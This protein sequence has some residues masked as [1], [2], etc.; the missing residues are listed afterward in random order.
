VSG[1]RAL[2]ATV[3]AVVGACAES[4]RSL[5]TPDTQDVDTADTLDPDTRDPDSNDTR[6]PDSNDTRDLDS[7]DTLDLDSNDTLD[8]DSNDTLDPDTSN[9][10]TLRGPCPRASRLGGFQVTAELDYAYVEGSVSDGVVPVTVLEV[11]PDSELGD[12]RLLAKRNPFCDPPCESG[13]TCD[14]D[15]ACIAYPAPLDL[16]VVTVQGLLAPVSMTALEPGMSYFETRLPNPPWAAGAALSL[17]SSGGASEPLALHALAIPTLVPL[18]PWEVAS[19]GADP[20]DLDV[21]W[22]PP[23][24]PSPSLEVV[25]TLLID[26]HGNAPRS[27]ECRFADTGH[28]QVPRALLT[29]LVASGVSGYPS[30]RLVRRSADSQVVQRPVAGCIDL[31]ATSPRSVPVSVS[32]HIPCRKD[33]DC[34]VDLTCDRPTETCVP[35]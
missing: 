33:A 7:N 19:D 10:P 30:G 25:L 31:L 32:G 35:R 34:P 3:L 15:G 2:L 5:T 21:R 23:P 28:G 1:S 11:V 22:E 29:A 26:Q 9:P 12:C 13:E 27:L 14:F 18:G 24:T 17:S 16:G 8:P 6:D 4:E 20:A